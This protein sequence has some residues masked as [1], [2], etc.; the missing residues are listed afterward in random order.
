MLQD[1]LTSLN[2]A[3]GNEGHVTGSSLNL[4]PGNGGHD[5]RVISHLSDLPQV[6]KV[7][8]QGCL[9]SFNL[10]PWNEGHVTGLSH[11]SQPCPR[12]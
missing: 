2:L 7:M 5:G 3:P 10:A 1:R 9:T 4:A 12:E 11:I 8:L 6:M